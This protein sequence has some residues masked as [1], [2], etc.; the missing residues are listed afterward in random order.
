MERRSILPFPIHSIKLVETVMV[1]IEDLACGIRVWAEVPREG[2][3]AIKRATKAGREDYRAHIA[4][5]VVNYRSIV[6]RN[7]KS[8]SRSST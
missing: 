8:F 2:L 4:Q 5:L 1:P 7:T 6:E 3:D